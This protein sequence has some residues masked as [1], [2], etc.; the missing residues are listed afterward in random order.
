MAL[1]A[2]PEPWTGGV[3]ETDSSGRVLRFVEKP[4]P[5]Q[6]ST[7]LINAGIYVVEPSVLEMIPAGTVLRFWQGCVSEDAR[8]EG[9]PVY[10]MKPD[11]YIWD[12][13]TPERLAKAQHDFE[14][15]VLN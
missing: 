4:D 5:K 10:A 3:V 9:Q 13:G 2:S 14:Q 7:N 11:A 12:I 8:A 6:V 1:F 15:G